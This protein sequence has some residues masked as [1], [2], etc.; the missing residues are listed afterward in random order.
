VAD[1][2]STL[3]WVSEDVLAQPTQEDTVMFGGYTRRQLLGGLL[4]AL[5]AGLGLRP[6]QATAAPA[7]PAPPPSA[8]TTYSY[9]IGGPPS[10]MTVY[11]YDGTGQLVSVTHTCACATYAYDAGKRP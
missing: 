10:F 3:V 2:F 9:D 6:R 7:T 1:E 8:P 5:A 11:T 4:A